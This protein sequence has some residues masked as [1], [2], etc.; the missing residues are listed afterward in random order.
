LKAEPGAVAAFPGSA[1]ADGVAQLKPAVVPGWPVV[2][3]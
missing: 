1:I 2:G 3:L